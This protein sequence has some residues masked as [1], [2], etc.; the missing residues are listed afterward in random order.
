[1]TKSTADTFLQTFRENKHHARWSDN[2]YEASSTNS[3]C[4]VVFGQEDIPFISTLIMSRFGFT[5]FPLVEVDLTG[6]EF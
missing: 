5:I 2:L 1:L 4:D 3:G 6:Q